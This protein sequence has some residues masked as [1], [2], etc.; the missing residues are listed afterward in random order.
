MSDNNYA[1]GNQN[2]DPSHLKPSDYDSSQYPPVPEYDS[3]YRQWPNTEW[4]STAPIHPS[5]FSIPSSQSAPPYDV[6][7]YY[8]DDPSAGTVIE[9]AATVHFLHTENAAGDR[10]IM[11]NNWNLTKPAFSAD[12]GCLITASRQSTHLPFSEN[13]SFSSRSTGVRRSVPCSLA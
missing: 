12:P 4:S 3:S 7:A 9:H 2:Q 13:G 10:D 5:Y 1:Y 11:S 6:G 8:D